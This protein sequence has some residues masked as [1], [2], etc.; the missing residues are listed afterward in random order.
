MRFSAPYAV[1]ASNKVKTKKGCQRETLRK[2][3]F[4][5]FYAKRK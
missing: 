4:S 1:N 2:E 5:L 3:V